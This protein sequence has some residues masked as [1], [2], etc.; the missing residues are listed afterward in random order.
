VLCTLC[1][2]RESKE[3]RKR[4]AEC[5]A[6]VA[7]QQWRWKQGQP[8]KARPVRKVSQNIATDPLIVAHIPLARAMARRVAVRFR[9]RDDSDVI[10][11]ALYGLV[12]AGRTF[13][14]RKGVPFAAWAKLEIKSAVYNELQKQ[15]KRQHIAM[16]VAE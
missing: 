16:Q 10:G 7:A 15:W 2:K 13:D 8:R 14:A 11:D 6:R 3:G 5:A 4:C 9:L 12:V 1:E